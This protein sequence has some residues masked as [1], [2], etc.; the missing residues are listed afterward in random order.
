MAF[1]QTTRRFLSGLTL[2]A[3][4]TAV[5]AE[6]ADDFATNLY[7]GRLSE[8]MTL[9]ETQITEHPEDQRA[10]FALGVAQFLTGVENLGQGFYRYGLRSNFDTSFQGISGLPFLRLPVPANPQPEQVTYSGLREVL[11]GFVNDLAKA[12]ETLGT[13]GPTAFDLP[14]DLA[15]I[16]LDFDGD[17]ASSDREALLYTFRAVSQRATSDTGYMADFDQSDAVWLQGYCH[18]ISAMAEFLLAHDWEMA[19]EQTFHGLFPQSDLPS[20]ELATEIAKVM[21][22]LSKYGADGM[23]YPKKPA[24]M[25]WNEWRNDPVYLEYQAYSFLEDSLW[26]ASAAD[27]VAFIHLF[28][29]PVEEPARMG[30]ARGHLM[31]M[32]ALSRENWRRIKA[33][34]DD[35]REWVPGPHQSGI[36]Q[37]MRVTSETVDAWHLFLDEFEAILEGHRLIKHWRFVDRGVNVRRIFDEPRTFDPVLIAQGSAVIPYLETGDLVTARTAE[38]MFDLFEGGFLAYFIWFN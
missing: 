29:W 10:V 11:D 24:G 36:F 26:I 18:L 33:E 5:Q 21:N 13:V 35:R 25:N 19:F 27:L 2:L 6:F 23:A 12:E 30:L 22:A 20:S 17:G 15:R 8:A 37:R 31:E 14:L 3:V 1:L 34:T 32:I 9:A 28:N 16:H 4:G 38:T 7:E